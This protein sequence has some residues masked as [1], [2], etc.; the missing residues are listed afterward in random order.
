MFEY[1]KKGDIVVSLGII[2]L[3]IFLAIFVFRP[4]EADSTYV[5]ISRE[6]KEIE[7]IEF[8]KDNIGKTLRLDSEYGYNVLEI[9]DKKI[10]SIDADCKE[11]VHMKQGWISKPG[12]TLVCLPHK[13][14]VEIKAKDEKPPLIDHINY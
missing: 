5:S 10:R 6:G 11:K 4:R 3:S 2:I 14:V 7:R 12:Q 1:I 8:T 13:L 9:G